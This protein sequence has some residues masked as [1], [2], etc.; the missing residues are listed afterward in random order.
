MSV[1]AGGAP[2]SGQTAIDTRFKHEFLELAQQAKG[3][4]GYVIPVQGYS[5]K[6]GSA[7]LNQ[8]LSAE[9]AANVTALLDRHSNVQDRLSS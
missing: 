6:V 8:K 4:R 9:C 7:A 2:G 1:L 5:S 3:G